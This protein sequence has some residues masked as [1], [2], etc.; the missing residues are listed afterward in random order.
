MQLFLSYHLVVTPPLPLA[1]GYVF[2]GGIQ[3]APVDDYLAASCNFGILAE[4]ELTS[5]YSALLHF[6]RR[7][8]RYALTSS[9]YPLKR[10]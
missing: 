10:I 6:L 8:Q 4:D 5:F 1:M 2:F 7:T 3:C 9:V